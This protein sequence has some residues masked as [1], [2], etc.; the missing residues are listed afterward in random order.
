MTAL[1][2]LIGGA[3]A[4]SVTSLNDGRLSNVAD[5]QVLR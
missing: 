4:A 3:Q 5:V 1:D 2:E